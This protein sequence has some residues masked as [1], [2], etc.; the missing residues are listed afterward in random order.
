MK[1]YVKINSNYHLITQVV[2]DAVTV[3]VAKRTNHIFLVDVSGSMSY[4]LHLIRKQLKNNLSSIMNEGDTITIIWFSG[5]NECGILKEEVEVRSLK[6]LED[7][8]KAIDRWLTPIGLTAFCKPLHLTT[9]VIGRVKKNRPDSLFSLVFL[10]DGHNN[11]CEFSDVLKTLK[12]L[13]PELAAACFVEYGY[14]ADAQRLTQ[15]ASVVGGEKISAS[16][17]EEFEPIFN[18]KISSPLMSGK[19]TIVEITDPYLYDFAYSVTPDGGVL[20]YDI[21]Q[22]EHG[23]N[24]MV[25]G[26]VKE[27]YFFSPIAIGENGISP[28]HPNPNA[29]TALYAGIYVLADKLKNDDAEKLFYALGDNHYYRELL[30]AFGKQKLNAFKNNIKECV[31]DIAKRFPEGKNEIEKVDDNAYC[32]MNLIEDLGAIEDCLFFPGHEDFVYNRIGRKR[33]QKG[34]TLSDEDQTK[35]AEAKNVKEAQAVLA[36]LAEKNVDLKFVAKDEMAGSPLSNLVWNEERANL[37]VLV[38]TEGTVD[39]PANKW[40]ITTIPTFKY[41][42]YTLIKDGIVNVQLLPVSYTDALYKIVMEKGLTADITEAYI[43]LDLSTLPLINKTMVKSISA[44]ALARQQW[45]LTKLQ[46]DK[47]VYDYYRKQ[48]FPKESKTYIEDYGQDAADWLK[49]IGITDYSGFAPKTDAV[50]SVDFYMS[51]RLATKIKGISALPKVEDVATKMNAGTAL[52][53]AEWLLKSALEEYSA[54]LLS[55]AFLAQTAEQQTKTLQDYLISK[56]DELNKKKRKV[57]QELAQIKFSL[58][59][60]KKWFIEF[61]TFDLNKLS[62]K[63]DGFDLDF[64]FDLFEKEEKI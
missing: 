59:L 27:I 24:I 48:L 30:G 51:V 58:I 31:G 18:K 26:D 9:E 28:V 61:P 17:F 4:E 42:T 32:L 49:E 41:N 12:T 6:T 39:L 57:M 1:N 36:E 16:S 63:L 25:G 29:E 35:L 47:K 43:I 14:Y 46:G 52:K 55:P 19:K 8:N 33:V 2:S 21:Q 64:T 34:G 5:Y 15:M 13:E 7:L 53:P 37:S 40:N 38:R 62:L 44:D 56:S 20:L 50:E 22:G 10:T 11:N 45:E 54:Q 23:C 3:Q 60:S